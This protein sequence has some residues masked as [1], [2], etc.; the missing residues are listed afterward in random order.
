MQYLHTHP[1]HFVP[2]WDSL[3]LCLSKGLVHHD[4]NSHQA[5]TQTNTWGVGGLW[6]M[7]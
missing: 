3:H 6:G 4:T 1:K 5:V 2:S 7:G